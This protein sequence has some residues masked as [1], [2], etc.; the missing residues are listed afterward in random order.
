MVDTRAGP[1]AL[2]LE[3]C[4]VAVYLQGDARAPPK[5]GSHKGGVIQITSFSV[6]LRPS[7]H[8]DLLAHIRSN[9]GGVGRFWKISAC[10][11]SIRAGVAPGQRLINVECI[12]LSRHLARAMTRIGR[13]A[14]VLVRVPAAQPGADEDGAGDGADAADE[15]DDA[16]AREVDQRGA[17]DGLAVTVVQEA[18]AAPTPMHDLAPALPT[19]ARLQ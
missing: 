18:V 10:I 13:R 15:V 3:V 8:Y 2:T 5:F 14:R 6:F 4:L 11:P 9:S 12:R 16:A 1:S 7:S 17:D 19:G